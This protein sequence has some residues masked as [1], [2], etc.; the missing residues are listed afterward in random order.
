ML[1][2]KENKTQIFPFLFQWGRTRC[3]LAHC[4]HTNDLF[5]NENK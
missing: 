4:V 5:N 3:F 2:R 1:S